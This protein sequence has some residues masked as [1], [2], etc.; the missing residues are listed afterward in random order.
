M[1]VMK[2]NLKLSLFL[3][4]LFSGA[5]S[6]NAQL[7]VQTSGDVKI[8]KNMEIQRDLLVNDEMAVGTTIDEDVALNVFKKGPTTVTSTPTYGIKTHVSMH[9]FPIYPLYG[10]YALAN[11]YNATSVQYPYPVVGVYGM[12]TKNDG[13]AT[14]AAGVAG[15]AYFKGGIG[16]FGG[17]N[18]LMTSLPASAKYAGYFKGRTKVDGTLLANVIVLDGDTIHL[19]NIRSIASRQSDVINL[20]RPVTYTFKPD[21][22]WKDDEDMQR[23]MEG[24]HYGFI[25][26]DVQKILPEIIYERDGQMSINYIE[27]IPLLVQK[28]QELSAEVETLKNQKQ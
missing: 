27:L 10:L 28:V 20:L 22:T 4:A 6:L 1:V 26:Q 14:F 15:V 24:T 13:I 25:A 7:E 3:V 16:V 2:R 9:Q 23:D 8:N 11:A 21:S 19:N 12:A 5:T 18:N 17:T